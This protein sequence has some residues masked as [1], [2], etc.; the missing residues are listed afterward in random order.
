MVFVLTQ[1][2]ASADVDV[3]KGYS[4]V[5]YGPPLVGKTSTLGLDP[6]FKYLLID[7]DKN[8]T[9]L[10]GSPNVMIASCDTFQDYLD[11]KE[12]VRRGFFLINNKQVPINV[13]CIV[14]DSFTSME[15]KI[16]AHV[17]G[18]FAPNRRRE[19]ASKFGA[20]TD[21]Q[22]LQDMEIA[23]IRDWQA[24]TKRV[25]N[26]VNILWIG[27][28]MTNTNDMGIA[29]SVGIA[30]QGKYAAPRIASAVDAVFYMFKKANPANKEEIARFIYTQQQGIILAEARMPIARRGELPPVIRDPKW[31]EVFG[32]LGYKK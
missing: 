18:I 7:F 23:E 14:V 27:H 13:D 11:V 30:L 28:D 10:E 26:P 21:W 19:I 15:E 32:I 20:Q 25:N 8:T 1:A 29:Q 9:V 12:A 17:V 24:M 5:L 31:S 3:K 4:A 6:N 22:D 2:G 16:K